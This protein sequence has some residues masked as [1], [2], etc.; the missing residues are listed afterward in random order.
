[1][2]REERADEL[3]VHGKV[4]WK[5]R[6]ALKHKHGGMKVSL[7]VLA[8]FGM[9]NLATL[10]L[11]VNFVSYFTGIMHYE[12]ADAANMVTNYMGVN[13]MLSIVVAVLA[14]TWI[15]RYKS[16]VISGIVESLGLAL[17]TIQ[18]R[19]GSL[20][21]PICDL[22]NVRDA[23][24]EKLSGK[25]EAFLFIGLYLLA[26]GSA[27]LK[28]SLPSHGADQFD[29]RDP[30]EAMQM[31][32]FFNGLFLALC[33]GGAVSLT[34]N[35]YIQ[36]NNGWIWGFGI[37]TV[38]IVL[39][40]I[41]FASGLPL[42]R[43]HA[44]HST[45][46]ILEIIQVYVAAIRNRNLPL[47]ANPIQLYEI[48]QDK[49]AAVEIEYQPHR[50]IFR[51]LDKA[52]IKSRSDEQPENQE[53]PNPWKLCRVTQVENAKII[54]SMLPIFC[55]SIIMTLCLAQLQTF[56]IQQGSTM[57]TRIAKHFN[58]PPASIPIIPVAFLIVFVPFYD[59]ICVPF[60]RKFTGI[61]TGITHLQ[62]IG[63]GLILS[64]ISMAVAAIIEVKRKGVARDNNMLNALPV[65][66]PLPISIFWISFQ[67]FVFG[68]A[69]MFT[70]V[71]LLEF[72]YSEA[73][74]SL[75]STATC[76]LWCAMAL[77]YFLS[78]IMVKIVN[79][80]TKNITASGGWLQG[81]NINR[82]HLN[83]FYLLLSIL[84]LINFFVYLFVSKRYKYRP[85]HPAV[86]GGNSEE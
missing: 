13:Y 85:Q 72:F 41:I 69:D 68:I 65:L 10:S 19:V 80:A 51:F 66:Q 46:G 7:L 3:V 22:Y 50:D 71:G 17:L 84:S 58:I 37:S 20:T 48:Q 56:S 35:V 78:S 36:D 9:E 21:P 27:G 25:Q 44:A 28:A 76:F 24:C 74:K 45:N 55:C 2:Q 16:V 73:P 8:A 81:N 11:A 39:G 30:K 59:R 1:M 34:F 82:N 38:A 18:A 49:E 42:Y 63:V 32:S 47:P 54:L 31:S 5:G 15:G 61:P 70:Y 75:K 6:K 67:Y 12:L 86:T 83:L 57:N 33:V 26:F 53:T 60:L 62:R 64:S 43:I 40:T 79:S 14:D 4:D 52:A 77:G 29:E 23:H